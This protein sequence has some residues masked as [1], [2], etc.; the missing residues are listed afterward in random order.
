MKELL[1]VD[2][3][4]LHHGYFIESSR[5]KGRFEILSYIEKELG[6]ALQANP[7]FFIEEYETFSIDDARALK[8]RSQVK[9]LEDTK[10]IFVILFHFITREAQNALLKLFEEPTPDTHF[11]LISENQALLLPTLRSRL[12]VIKITDKKDRGEEARIFLKASVDERIKMTERFKDSE[13]D[14][15]KSEALALLSEIEEILGENES[16]R[17]RGGVLGELLALKKYLYD[18]AP[19][20]K[21]IIDY[22]ALRLPVIK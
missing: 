11:F 17:Q 7:D 12:F 15:K 16:L 9:P 1:K 8:E 22:L 2:K 18:R 13:N 5:E 14:T 3:N 19:S 21:M 20:V 6:I 4:A 10:K